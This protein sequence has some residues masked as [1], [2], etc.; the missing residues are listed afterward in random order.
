MPLQW[1][2][3]ELRTGRVTGALPLVG[4]QWAMSMDDAGQLSG[5]APLADAAV[6]AMRPLVSAEVGRCFL[7]AAWADPAGELTVLEAGPVWTHNLKGSERSL[8]LGAAGLWSYYDHRKL[9]KV[10]DTFGGAAKATY[11]V[12]PVSLGTVAKRLV[13]LAH[14][15]TAG[16]LPVV[17]PADVAGDVE[18]EYPGTELA[19]VG[20]KLRE[21]TQEDDGPEIAFV[22]RLAEDSDG[23]FIEWVMELGTPEEPWLTQGPQRDDWIWDASVPGGD[24]VDIDVQI[25][26]TQ[27]ASRAWAA[28]ASSGEDRLIE[29]RD[30]PALT[31]LGWPLL[32]TEVDGTD[33]IRSALQ[34]A[35]R[36]RQAVT[37][38]RHPIQAWT[39]HTRPSAHPA[40]GM[41]RPGHWARVVIGRDHDYLNRGEYRGRVVQV[42][43]R[44]DE[45]VSIQFQ[46]APGAV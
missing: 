28:G 3:G 10:L 43:G 22:P 40:P 14:T 44:D 34:L 21:L 19:W 4:A 11:E 5:T 45:S 13:E 38:A 32:E 9:V 12:G 7:A 8:R 42:S 37:A 17:L 6:R 2:V 39:I 24:V 1:L 25:D 36:T 31:D 23:R 16:E 27:L 41:V 15:H 46:P 29:Y 20:G 33:S 18:R 26:G 30:D 35:S